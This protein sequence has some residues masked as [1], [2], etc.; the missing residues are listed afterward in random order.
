MPV[1]GGEPRRA[2]VNQRVV[3]FGLSGLLRLLS[4]GAQSWGGLAGGQTALI[5]EA[6][7]EFTDALTFGAVAVEAQTER[8]G[9]TRRARRAAVFFAVG[10]AAIATT[11]TLWEIAHEAGEWLA[12]LDSL[13]LADH[14]VVA[15]GIALILSAGVFALNF[16][17]RNSGKVSDK[18]AWRDSLRDFVIPGSVLAL[19]ALRAPH[20]AEFLLETGSLIYC[21]Y[22]VT[23]L[24]KGWNFRVWRKQPADPQRA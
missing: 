18:F 10:A 7:E 2:E 13:S 15:A 12:P 23:Q 19:A 1:P 9:L 16:K 17:P 8:R 21:W 20:I 14:D 5:V 24:M 3:R 22:N 11:A 6:G 4:A